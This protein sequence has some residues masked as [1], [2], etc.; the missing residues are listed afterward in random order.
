MPTR[1]LDESRDGYLT[2]LGYGGDRFARV[3]NP[4]KSY[5]CQTL[6]CVRNYRSATAAD[7]G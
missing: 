6:G 3:F 7:A 5:H 4:C 1:I 2:D